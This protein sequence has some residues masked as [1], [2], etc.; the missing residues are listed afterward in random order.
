MEERKGSTDIQEEIKIPA[1]IQ[2]EITKL[3]RR[4]K[5]LSYAVAGFLLIGAFVGF[6]VFFADSASAQYEN[7]EYNQTVAPLGAGAG[8]GG[9]GCC[10]SGPSA[11]PQLPAEEL[12]AQA[13]ELYKQETGR[14][15][16]KAQV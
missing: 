6:K 12:Q 7:Y 5:F 11:G 13:L 16:V 1:D 8:A 15:D 2:D 14:T 4:E 9:G 3:R 10:G